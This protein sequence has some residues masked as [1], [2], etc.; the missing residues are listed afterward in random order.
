MVI[1]ETALGDVSEAGEIIANRQYA[2]TDK[3]QNIFD[4]ISKSSEG[5]FQPYSTREIKSQSFLSQPE[6]DSQDIEKFCATF[7]KTVLP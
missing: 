4:M 1:Y 7:Q 6:E 3:A 2:F 5:L